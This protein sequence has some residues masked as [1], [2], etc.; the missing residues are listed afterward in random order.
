MTAPSELLRRNAMSQWEIASYRITH[1]SSSNVAWVTDVRCYD[2]PDPIEAGNPT[3]NVVIRFYPE[4]AAIPADGWA[5]GKVNGIPIINFP[6][7]RYDEVMTTIRDEK[8]VGGS[9]FSYT[10]GYDLVS[11]WGISTGPGQE[12]EMQE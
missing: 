3:E 1:L 11:G 6:L 5:G 7:S 8:Y 9:D 12:G 2:I 10:S 4:G